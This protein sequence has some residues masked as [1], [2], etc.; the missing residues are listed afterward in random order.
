MIYFIVNKFGCNLGKSK[1]KQDSDIGFPGPL[2]IPWLSNGNI[3]LI[4]E[5]FYGK[6]IQASDSIDCTCI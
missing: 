5:G 4:M 3:V 2:K 6:K 1:I